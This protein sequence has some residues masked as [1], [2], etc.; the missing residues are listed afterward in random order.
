MVCFHAFSILG[1]RDL[2]SLLV[3]VGKGG[4][5]TSNAEDCFAVAI[6]KAETIIGHV[7]CKFFHCF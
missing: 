7:P 5:K 3:F 2:W 1:Q 4:T 6:V